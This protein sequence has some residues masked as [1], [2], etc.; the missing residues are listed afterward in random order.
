[1]G[2]FPVKDGARFLFA[3]ASITDM[4]RADW[5]PPLGS[6]YVRLFA[7]LVAWQHPE[8]NIH[9]IN[10]GIGGNITREL[11]ERW[12]RDVL[13]EEPHWVAILVGINDC[14]GWMDQT[15]QVAERD[16]R[17]DYG[18]LLEQLAPLGCRVVLMDPF[19]LA[20][21]GGRWR[22]DAEQLAILRRLAVYHRVV[23]DLARDHGALHL[24]LH[25]RFQDLMRHR[26]PSF[27]APEPVHP[28]PSGH[29]VI[30][31]ELYRALCGDQ[32]AA[33]RRWLG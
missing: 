24:R 30:A 25:R 29:M 22:G 14:M 33:R 5:A 12:R 15:A 28:H 19:Y 13:A 1:M 2:R 9:W 31:L 10:R 17:T 11:R 27:Y 23:A 6:G 21:A 4:G 3:G 7:D 16:Y 18:W 20:T 8:R 32:P 26:P